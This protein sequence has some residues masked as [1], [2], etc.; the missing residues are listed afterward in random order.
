MTIPTLPGI[1]PK[2]ITTQRIATRVLF[3]GPDD[4]VPVLF[5]H[6]NSSSATWWE[7]TM[8][9]LPAG[10]RG[11]APDHWP[12]PLAGHFC[13]YAGGLNPDNIDRHLDLMRD[14][15]GDELVWIDMESGIRTN[16]NFDLSK[17]RRVLEIAAEYAE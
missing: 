5:L 9:S 7:E 11:I 15:A 6:G 3:S 1:T 8:L 12:P 2:M 10:F 14:A 17:C 16:D 4:G 13:G